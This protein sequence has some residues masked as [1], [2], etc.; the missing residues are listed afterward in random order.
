MGRI[1]DRKLKAY[2]YTLTPIGGLKEHHGIFD[3][4]NCYNDLF[5]MFYK[6]K[7]GYLTH[8]PRQEGVVYNKAIWYMQP[9]PEGALKAFSNRAK[10]LK[11]KYLTQA[12]GQ[13][14]LILKG[15]NE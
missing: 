4:P 2:V 11:Q 10:T 3:R 1:A 15:A 13:E 12:I 5:W 6:D 8:V 14:K 9:N 7:G